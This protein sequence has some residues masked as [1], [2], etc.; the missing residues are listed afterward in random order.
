MC[1]DQARDVADVTP[2]HVYGFRTFVCL[3]RDIAGLSQAAQNAAAP[4]TMADRVRHMVTARQEMPTATKT[5]I[6]QK[7]YTWSGLTDSIDGARVC[8]TPCW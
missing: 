7:A 4:Q 3:R 1:R 8:C 2:R 5:E 6:L